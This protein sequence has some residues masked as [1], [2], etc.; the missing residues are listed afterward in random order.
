MIH[1][2]YNYC[3]KTALADSEYLT[4]SFIK[5]QMGTLKKI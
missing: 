2:A 4:Q 5:C 1:K 3:L